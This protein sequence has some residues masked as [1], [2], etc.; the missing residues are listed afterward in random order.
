MSISCVMAQNNK[1]SGASSPRSSRRSSVADVLCIACSQYE[2]DRSS[3]DIGKVAMDNPAVMDFCTNVCSKIIEAKSHLRG[4]TK[5][6][7]EEV[8]QA[9]V[10]WLKTLKTDATSGPANK[11]LT[12]TVT[13]FSALMCL[14]HL[15][16]HNASTSP[17]LK[18][19]GPTAKPK[20]QRASVLPAGTTEK[21]I[22][23][24]FMIK[25]SRSCTEAACSLQFCKG[26][27]EF[28]Q[29][30][31]DLSWEDATDDCLYLKQL[32]KHNERCHSAMCTVCTAVRKRLETQQKLAAAEGLEQ[33]RASTE[34]LDS[35]ASSS[36]Q[37]KTARARQA[38]SVSMPPRPDA[39]TMQMMQA[40]QFAQQQQQMQQQQFQQS[41]GY[42]MMMYPN[43]MWQMMPM[44]QY[45]Q[46]MQQM[47]AAPSGP[48][49]F[50]HPMNYPL[51]QQQQLLPGSSPAINTMAPGSPSVMS[52]DSHQ[53]AMTT[54][55][56]MATTMGSATPPSFATALRQGRFKAHSTPVPPN[57][58][59][60]DEDD[61]DDDEDGEEEQEE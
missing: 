50:V 53:P 57:L 28:I 37:A 42:P 40:Q 7:D 56:T 43:S 34:S 16:K 29:K 10:P 32:E 46:P 54:A 31:D 39:A 20:K 58:N 11:M 61:D 60:M 3:M 4:A 1:A 59:E 49:G 6:K 41:M 25:H 17:I 24:L 15:L 26:M 19:L 30:A 14:K 44:Q 51:A 12:D 5:S 33:L 47:F 2:G 27:K 18:R 35:H 55:M 36:T 48:Y 22:K 23:D 21:L 45:P 52:T 38:R 9:Y 13:T 8:T